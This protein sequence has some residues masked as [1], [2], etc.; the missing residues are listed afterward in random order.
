MF[1]GFR[2]GTAE[3]QGWKHETV[4][5]MMTRNFEFHGQDAVHG[6]CFAYCCDTGVTSEGLHYEGLSGASQ[7]RVAIAILIMGLGGCQFPASKET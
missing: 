2:C 4:S 6:E 7:T 5:Y 1:D 3:R